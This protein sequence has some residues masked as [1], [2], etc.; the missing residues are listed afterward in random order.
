MCTGGCQ[1]A[2]WLKVKYIY[3]SDAR[4]SVKMNAQIRAIEGRLVAETEI[5]TLIKSS[6]LAAP[7]LVKKATS[8]VVNMTTSDFTRLFLSNWSLTHDD[9]IKWEHFPRYWPFVR[10]IHRCPVNSPHKGQYR[11]ALMFFDMRLNKLLG[12][13]SRRR[14]LRRHRAHYDVTVKNKEMIKVPYY[15]QGDESACQARDF[16]AHRVCNSWDITIT[17]TQVHCSRVTS[18]S[19]L[20]PPPVTDFIVAAAVSTTTTNQDPPHPSSIYIYIYL[21]QWG[22]VTY[23]IWI[24]YL[25]YSIYVTGPTSDTCASV[26]YADLPNGLLSGDAYVRHWNGLS[27]V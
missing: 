5:V 22:L 16:S 19:S 17:R 3:G 18:S 24:I 13:Q 26:N 21:I 7:K 1:K 6:L 12:K 15:C 8:S 27:L 10:G 2:T 14:F 23:G 25:I 20:W 9:V 11:R 4:T